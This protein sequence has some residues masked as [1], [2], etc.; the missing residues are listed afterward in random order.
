MAVDAALWLILV[1]MIGWVAL[2]C[3]FTAPRRFA[4]EVDKLRH[5][6][7]EGFAALSRWQQSE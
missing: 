5:Q 7:Q 4:R 6:A 3:Y 1:G 2:G